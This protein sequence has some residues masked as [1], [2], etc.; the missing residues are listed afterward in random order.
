MPE[1]DQKSMVVKQEIIVGYL[2]AVLAGEEIDEDMLRV[3]SSF[4]N[5]EYS[6]LCF[7]MTW[8]HMA[9]VVNVFAL[10]INGRC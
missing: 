1:G 6:S 4:Y 3:A 8:F 10:L 5:S 2:V 7:P 9:V